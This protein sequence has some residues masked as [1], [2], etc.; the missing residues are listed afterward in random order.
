MKSLLLIIDAQNDFCRPSGSLYVPGA[1]GDMIRLS[2]FIASRGSELDHIVLTQD[3][4]QVIDIS[5]PHF[6]VNSSGNHPEAFTQI[7]PSDVES[8]KWKSIIEP[9]RSLRYL[10]SLNENGEY[11]HVIWPEHCIAGSEGAAIVSEVM[12]EVIKWSRGGKFFTI[13]QKGQNPYTEHFGALR[14]C[15]VDEADSRTSENRDLLR[16][17]E[18]YEVIYIAGE[19]RS[20]C[21][22]ST[23]KQILPY[24]ALAQRLMILENCMSPVRGFEHA[25]DEIYSQLPASNFIR[26]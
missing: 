1:D 11:P 7:S 2:H 3:W 10:R 4:H 20:H 8:G 26:A 22:A 25:G 18:G 19:A 16:L 21:V 13:I 23:V 24:P 12:S 5:H 6:W 15:L 17:M 9:E 14:A